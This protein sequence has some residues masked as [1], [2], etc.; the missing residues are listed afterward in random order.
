[1]FKAVENA[2]SSGKK[3]CGRNKA[4]FVSGIAKAGLKFET[5]NKSCRQSEKTKSD[6]RRIRP[7]LRRDPL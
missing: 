4:I 5:R 7:R 6:P 2:S 3:C 1:M